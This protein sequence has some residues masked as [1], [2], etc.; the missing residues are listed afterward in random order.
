MRKDGGSSWSSSRAVRPERH[1]NDRP[2]PIARLFRGWI[3]RK[4]V[5]RPKVV[6]LAPTTSILR[7]NGVTFASEQRQN[8]QPQQAGS[9]H[10]DH[11]ALASSFAQI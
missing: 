1:D 3:L 8:E 6:E 9:C 11:S 4:L 10:R 7:A 5:L 2:Q